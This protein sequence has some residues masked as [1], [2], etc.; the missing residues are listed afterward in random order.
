[1][2]T[3]K[4]EFKKASEQN[5]DDKSDFDSKLINQLDEFVSKLVRPDENYESLQKIDED[6]AKL[7][8]SLVKFEALK[9]RAENQIKISSKSYSD[10]L[11]ENESLKHKLGL[12]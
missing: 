5:N 1:M 2:S 6:I 7:D 12:N 8:S 3:I 4:T 10:L 11:T 9:A